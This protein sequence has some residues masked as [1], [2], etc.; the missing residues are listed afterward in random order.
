MAASE[1]QLDLLVSKTRMYPSCCAVTVIRFWWG[2]LMGYIYCPSRCNWSCPFFGGVIRAWSRCILSCFLNDDGA[3]HNMPHL[4]S[5]K[6]QPT[7]KKSGAVWTPWSVYLSRPGL[8]SIPVAE[9][10][11][12]WHCGGLA[13]PCEP[14]RPASQGQPQEGESPEQLDRQ[15][16]KSAQPAGGH[17]SEERTICCRRSQEQLPHSHRYS[18]L[19]HYRVAPMLAEVCGKFW[20]R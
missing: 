7:G 16:S 9:L 15:L 19:K 17:A 1:S 18:Y 3:R 6:S 12:R 11:Q 13:R 10:H 20:H 4:S 2:H 14:R 5:I 8:P